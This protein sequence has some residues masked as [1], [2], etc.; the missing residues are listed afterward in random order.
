LANF[1]DFLLINTRNYKQTVTTS[2]VTGS[3][4]GPK[5]VLHA[6]HIFANSFKFLIT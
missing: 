4:R 2:N 1:A 3:H 5:L 6:Q